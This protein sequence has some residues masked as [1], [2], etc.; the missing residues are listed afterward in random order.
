MGRMPDTRLRPSVPIPRY[1]LLAG[2][3]ACRTTSGLVRRRLT[4]AESSVFGGDVQ[5]APRSLL[6]LLALMDLPRAAVGNPLN[7]L[8]WHVDTLRARRRRAGCRVL[9]L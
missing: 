5:P 8:H 1:R 7:I 3:A 4:S 2:S 6:Q 9:L